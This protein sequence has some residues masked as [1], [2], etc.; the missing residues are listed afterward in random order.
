MPI[1]D[2]D[3]TAKKLGTAGCAKDAAVN[4]PAESVAGQGGVGNGSVPWLKLSV[5]KSTGGIQ[6]VY[7]INTAGGKAPATCAGQKA[8]FE[9]QYATE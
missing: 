8:A 5:K 2:L 7:R 6:E 1:F 3:T 4:A 9:V